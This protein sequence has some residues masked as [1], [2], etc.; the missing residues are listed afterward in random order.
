MTR[1]DKIIRDIKGQTVQKTCEGVKRYEMSPRGFA[2][3]RSGVF[4][5]VVRCGDSSGINRY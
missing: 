2:N 1:R 5:L 3:H 4:L